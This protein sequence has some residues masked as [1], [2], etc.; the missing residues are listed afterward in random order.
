MFHSTRTI[1]SKYPLVS[2]ARHIRT[3]SSSSSATT[4]SSSSV[5]IPTASQ[6]RRHYISS[7][8]PMVAFG[9]MD[10]T[11]L[12]HAGNAIDCTLGVYFGL[13]TLAAAA[14]GGLIS[15]VS[16]ILFG[17]T[18]ETLIK[19]PSSLLTAE[20][21]QLP[22]VRRNRIMSQACG[23]V[24]GC[25]LGLLNLLLIDTERSSTLKLEQI[26][27]EQEESFHVEVNNNLYDDKTVFTVQSTDHYG[28]LASLTAAFTLNDCSIVDISLE[29]MDNGI[30]K[31]VFHVVS[32]SSGERLE[33][34]RLPIVAKALFDSSKEGPNFLKA[35]VNDLLNEN[36]QLK[37][38]LNKVEQKLLGRHMTLRP[39]Q[40]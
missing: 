26:M 40:L 39:R 21:R 16:G 11:I 1:I 22:F 19:V 5:P 13:S 8:T 28:L 36:S 15:N 3:F 10:Q 33:D 7:A 9:F 30:V 24:F 31:D 6:L 20:Q 34:E 17:G 23:V 14:V 35:Q 32:Q 37:E 4:E 12:I 18:V 25:T 2:P 27:D 38:K 29:S